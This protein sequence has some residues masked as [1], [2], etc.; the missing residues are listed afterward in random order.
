[1]MADQLGVATRSTHTS[2]DWSVERCGGGKV[3]QR[4]KVSKIWNGLGEFIGKKRE[5]ILHG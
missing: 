5:V 4:S 1:M 2:Q 3:L